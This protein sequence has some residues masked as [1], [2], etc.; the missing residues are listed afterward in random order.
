MGEGL[1]KVVDKS[2]SVV[3]CVHVFVTNDNFR[4]G[5]ASFQALATNTNWSV[6]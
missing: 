2:R 5:W 1:K 3:Q 6:G 4:I